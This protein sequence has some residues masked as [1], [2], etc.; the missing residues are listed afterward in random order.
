LHKGL[1]LPRDNMALVQG[2]GQEERFDYD[3]AVRLWQEHEPDGRII[4][5]SD[6]GIERAM[7]Q[8]RFQRRA[9]PIQSELHVD[10]LPESSH[11]EAETLKQFI[12]QLPEDSAN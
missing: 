3:A 7:Q 1:A 2:P 4:P 10:P 11:P 12:D 9:T 8:D 5:I 6:P